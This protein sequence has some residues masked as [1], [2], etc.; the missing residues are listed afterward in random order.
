[1]SA[2][3]PRRPGSAPPSSPAK[4]SH[5]AG[6]DAPR[7]ATERAGGGPAGERRDDGA[8]PGDGDAPRAGA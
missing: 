4:P 3:Q 8:R 1:M 6:A 7:S 2:E 5:P